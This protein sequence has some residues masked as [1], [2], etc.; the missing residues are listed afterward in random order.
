MKTAVNFA[1]AAV[2]VVAGLVNLLW[3]PDQLLA[4]GSAC[5]YVAV[6]E[7]CCGALCNEDLGVWLCCE[8]CP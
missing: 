8:K 1:L 2:L 3:L 5:D 4:T 6:P 7:G